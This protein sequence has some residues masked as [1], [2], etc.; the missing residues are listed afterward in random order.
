MCIRFYAGLVAN[1]Y[2]FL[3]KITF[4]VFFS[5]EYTHKKG[6]QRTVSVGEGQGERI[7]EKTGRETK[8]STSHWVVGT[9]IHF[10]RGF[11]VDKT[12]NEA[13]TMVSG[14]P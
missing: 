13:G 9:D 3:A 1:I 6:Y 7:E 11:L 2:S 14:P 4:I 10:K 8:T 5:P 12:E